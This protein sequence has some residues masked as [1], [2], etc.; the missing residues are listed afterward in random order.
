MYNLENKSIQI[1]VYKRQIKCLHAYLMVGVILVWAQNL[2]V[3]IFG[4]E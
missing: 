4:A 3:L 2:Q 1:W